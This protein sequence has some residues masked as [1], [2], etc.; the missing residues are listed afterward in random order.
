MNTRMLRIAIS[1]SGLFLG[2]CCTAITGNHQNVRVTSRPSGAKVTVSSTGDSITTPGSFDLVRNRDYIL[3]AEY[4]GYEP[5]EKELKHKRQV[6]LLG[7][8]LLGPIGMMIDSSNGAS[9]KLT[10]KE[11]HFRFM[12]L[13]PTMDEERQK[14]DSNAPARKVK[15]YIVTM[16]RDGN[17]MSTPVYENEPYEVPPA[18]VEQNDLDPNGVPL[19]VQP[20]RAQV[21]PSDSGAVLQRHAFDTG[22]EVYHFKY[23]EPGLMEEKGIF[24][25]LTLGYT[26]RSWV[27]ASPEE[28]PSHNKAGAMFRAEGR[29]AYGRVDYDGA[30]S[31]GTPYTMDDIDDFALEGRLLLGWDVLDRHMLHTPYA[32]IGYR[33]LNDDLSVDWYG[34]ERESN[35]LYLP[36]GYQFDSKSTDGWSWGARAEYDVFLWGNQKSRLGDVGLSDVDN[37]QTSGF[38]YRA[39]IKVQHKQKNGILIIEPF[40]RY[41]DINDSRIEY[42]YWGSG[43]EPANETTE[44]GLQLVWM[45]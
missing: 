43:Y 32:G 21:E 29:F 14:A 39:S 40:F 23:K 5:Q 30:L 37:R 24:Y 19:A 45:F 20:G 42:T 34:Y 28:S 17:A 10:P 35:Y 4:P 26:R 6:W 16:H 22:Q 3:V 2:G 11:V 27:P 31:D 9:D 25:G 44:Y 13:E 8:I 15:G 41:W 7:N 36:V 38:G 33:Y 12:W 1:L 18:K